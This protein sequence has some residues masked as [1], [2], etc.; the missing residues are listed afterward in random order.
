MLYFSLL[1]HCT[2]SSK[3][4]DRFF[5]FV[6]LQLVPLTNDLRKHEF[7]ERRKYLNWMLFV[8]SG[9]SVTSMPLP[10]PPTTTSSG[11]A[12]Y[13]CM[14]ADPADNP[15]HYPPR[16]RYLLEQYGH[17]GEK[18]HFILPDAV[19]S[20]KSLETTISDMA[21]DTEYPYVKFPRREP[22]HEYSYPKL[23]DTYSAIDECKM[24]SSTRSSFRRK[25]EVPPLRKSNSGTGSDP[26]KIVVGSGSSCSSTS[27]FES[28]CVS[29][30]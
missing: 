7:S 21:D 16:T 17:P 2:F 30:S 18:T 12:E 10:L 26:G 3:F 25:P 8:I 1:R 19:G 14:V 28:R 20:P 9:V 27:H 6:E 29:P 4:F 22:P 11:S 13:V 24:S 15:L 5:I 23:V